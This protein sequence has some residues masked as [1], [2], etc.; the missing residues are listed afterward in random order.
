MSKTRQARLIAR[1]LEDQSDEFETTLER[2]RGDTADL[3]TRDRLLESWNSG[4]WHCFC[5]LH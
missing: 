4:F 2:D 3:S 1:E 5:P